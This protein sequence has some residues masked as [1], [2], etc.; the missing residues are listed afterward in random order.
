MPHKPIE[1]YGIIGDLHTIALVGMDGSI[2]WCCLPHFDSPSVFAALLDDDRGGSFRIQAIGLDRNKQMYLPDT[3][4]LVTRFL[5]EDGVG[6]VVDF[7]PIRDPD[8]P[9]KTHQIVRVVRAIRGAVRFRLECRPAFDFARQEH[10][11]RLDPRGAIFE[12]PCAKFSRRCSPT[13]ITSA[14]IPRRPARPARHWGTSRR[15]SR[16]WASSAPRSTSTDASATT[17]DAAGRP[18]RQGNRS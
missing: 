7:M 12:A 1:S 8:E 15:R 14:C 10:T 2:D 5:G 13:P 17:P 3:N 4:V 9:V 16:T 18:R 11:V 6:E